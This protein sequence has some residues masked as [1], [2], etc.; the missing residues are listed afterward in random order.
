MKTDALLTSAV[1]GYNKI[2]GLLPSANDSWDSDPQVIP[3]LDAPMRTLVGYVKWAGLSTAVLAVIAGLVIVIGT[4]FWG[5]SVAKKAVMGI[6][7]ALGGG[8]AIGGVSAILEP[9][10]QF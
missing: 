10:I 7:I 8:V 2:T 5:W 4:V 6:V 3:G 9:F 1:I